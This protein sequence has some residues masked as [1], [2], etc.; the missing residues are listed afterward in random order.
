MSDLFGS[1]TPSL[2]FTLPDCEGYSSLWDERWCGFH[3]SVPQGEFFYSESFFN[4]RWS[5]RAIDYFLEN[6][7]YDWRCVDWR[8]MSPAEISALDFCHIRWQQEYI[9][10]YGKIIPLPRL[11]SW[12]GDPGKSYEYSGIKSEPHPWNDGLTHI[13]NKIQECAEHD[14]NCVLLN[15]YRDGNDSLS[16]H[17]DDE[18]ELGDKPDNSV[19][20]FW[21]DA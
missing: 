15:W 2:P 17:A 14:F 5:D 21:S 6:D 3:V 9:K 4:T 11:T 7:K 16:W 13:K 10:L 19:G 8:S 1:R 12:Y 20:K 18:K